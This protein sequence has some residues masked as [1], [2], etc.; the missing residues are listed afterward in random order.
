MDEVSLNKEQLER[1]MEIKKD[2]YRYA[3]G[4]LYI[5][6]KDAEIVKF[7]PNIAQ[8]ALID[9]VIYLLETKQPIRIIVLKARQ[10]GLSTA[11]EAL[12]YW[13]TATNRNVTSAIIAHEDAASRNLYNM[14]KRYYDNSNILFK[15]NRKYDTRSDLIS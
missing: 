2:F 8:K 14:F 7:E 11:I 6:N 12:I 4:N 3:K 15:P 5:K 10:M 13:Y 9:R 1:I